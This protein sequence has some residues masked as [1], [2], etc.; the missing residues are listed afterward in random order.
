FF[1]LIS[2][3]LPE[4]CFLD[5][6]FNALYVALPANPSTVIPAF[7]CAD[8]TAFCVSLPNI[9]SAVTPTSFCKS[10]T[11]PPRSFN[12]N[13]CPVHLLPTSFHFDVLA[14]FLAGVSFL[15]VSGLTSPSLESFFWNRWIA[16]TWPLAYISVLS[17]V[18]LH[19]VSC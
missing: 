8:L 17:S 11:A 14:G 6:L 4:S 15:G 2:V 19:H 5:D 13:T 18:L 10:L 7:F 3:F 9:P 12:R 16:F 1:F